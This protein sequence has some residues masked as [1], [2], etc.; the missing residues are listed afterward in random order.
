MA[1]LSGEVETREKRVLPKR[2]RARFRMAL[3]SGEV[4]TPPG[5]RGRCPLS[6]FRMALL[7]GEVETSSQAPFLPVILR[8]RM[9]LLSGEVETWRLRLGVPSLSGWVPDGFA[10]RG[11]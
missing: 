7:S 2:A 3:L 4:E 5:S 8:F 11:S 10:I 6:W 9:A 1:L